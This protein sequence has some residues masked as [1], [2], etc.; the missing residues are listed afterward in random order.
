MNKS[1]RE[2]L[3]KLRKEARKI[4]YRVVFRSIEVEKLRNKQYYAEH[5]E[6]QKE[7][8]RKWEEEHKE[9]RKKYWKALRKK[10]KALK[11]KNK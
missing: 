11:K 8:C 4:G 3:D 9:Y 1:T 6:E 5:K 2:K 7:R 10:R